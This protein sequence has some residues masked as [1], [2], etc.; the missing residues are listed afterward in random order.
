MIKG[1]KEKGKLPQ[2]IRPLSI[3]NRIILYK[4][5]TKENTRRFV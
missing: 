2:L 1:R 4:K 5:L 3:K